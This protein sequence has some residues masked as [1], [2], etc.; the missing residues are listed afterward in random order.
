MEEFKKSHLEILISQGFRYL[1]QNN[2][3]EEGDVNLTTGEMVVELM[4]C[5]TKK[6]LELLLKLFGE[7]HDHRIWD[8]DQDG[9]EL[10][11]MAQGV[12]MIRFMIKKNASL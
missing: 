11:E 4:P 10:R 5:R 1:Y 8:L 7:D 6:E 3:P 9:E 2:H 12:D